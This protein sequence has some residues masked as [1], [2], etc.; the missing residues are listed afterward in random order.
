[1]LVVGLDGKEYR[2]RPELYLDRREN[3]SNLHIQAR[4][5][6]HSLFPFYTISEELLLPGI[7]TKLYLDLYIQQLRLAVE[8]NGC[9]H[10]N[11]NHHFFASAKDFRRAQQRDRLKREWCEL[12]NI[13]LVELPYNESID[14]WRERIRG[15]D[16]RG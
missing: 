5:L 6:L 12:N 7:E 9:Q 14:Q 2:W 10:Y 8:A 11:Y 3:A 15:R 4:E 1:M 16:I 13:D